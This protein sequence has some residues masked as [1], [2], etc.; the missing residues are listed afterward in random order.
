MK[1]QRPR[2]SNINHRATLPNLSVRQVV[3]GTLVVVSVSLAF[4]F[5]FRFH[6]VILILFVAI[7][8]STAIRPVVEWLHRRGLPRPLGIIL[9]YCFL[10]AL[11]AGFIVLGFPLILRQATNI[12]GQV[13]GLYERLRNSMMDAPT[14]LF[15]RL[16]EALPAE[17]PFMAPPV[18]GNGEETPSLAQAWQVVGPVV[19]TILGTVAVFILAFS[20][21]LEAE[22]TKQALLLLL[23][24]EKRPEAREVL[25]TIEQKLGS[26]IVGQALLVVVIGVLSLIAYVIIGLPYALALAFFAGLMEAIPVVGPFLGAVPAILVAFSVDPSKVLW[27]IVA[28]LVIQ[29]LENTLLVPRVM[30]RTVGVHPLV[31]LLALIALGS[32]FGIVGALVAI[33]IAAIIQLLLDRY[34][35]T[36][37]VSAAEAVSG[38]DYLSVLRY[39]TKELVQD[40]RKQVRSNNTI[41]T[42]DDSNQI[43]DS[44][45]AIAADLDSI[46]AQHDT[47]EVT[48]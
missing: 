12:A 38:R 41:I 17:L 33:P 25:N 15:W 2:E 24:M 22:R 1:N 11:I 14:I 9:V 40:V 46:L 8:I 34:L 28:A 4:W 5:L 18:P 31:T 48:T 26:F 21:T 42:A 29:Q 36:P 7:V 27:V 39:E 3:I 16:G 13:P 35:L 47:P 6:H 30:N 20:W 44:L 43:E 32:L 37:D 45:E 10:L 23:P 19:N